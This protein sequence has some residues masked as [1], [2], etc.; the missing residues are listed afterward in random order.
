MTKQERENEIKFLKREC[1]SYKSRLIDIERRM[2][3]VSKSEARKLGNIIGRL[4]DW[5]N[6]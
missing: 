5:Q 3:V 2:E 1:N 4:E 6:R